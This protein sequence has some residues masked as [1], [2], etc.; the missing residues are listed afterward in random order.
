MLARKP[1]YGRV[2]TGNRTRRCSEEQGSVTMTKWEFVN[3]ELIATSVNS[4]FQRANVYA[5]PQ[6]YADPR[7]NDLR[8]ELAKKLKGVARQYENGLS[9]DLHTKNIKMIAD[10]LTAEFKRLLRH[11]RFRIGV[12]QKALN[13]YL[14]YL[15]CLG[16]IPTPPHCP[17]DSRIIAK[18][19]LTHAQKKLKWTELDSLEDYQ[20]LVDAGMRKIS[21]TAYK[22]LSDWELDE[23]KKD[24]TT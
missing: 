10:E 18:L 24:T 9:S 8:E 13:L 16:K 2:I 19:P 21:E 7:R 22:S 12:A 15:W 14:K 4:A 3:R 6:G 5:D 20:A 1:Q 23:W 17:F 11:G